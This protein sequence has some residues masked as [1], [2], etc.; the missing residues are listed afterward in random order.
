MWF[1]KQNGQ[2]IK[3]SRQFYTILSGTILTFFKKVYINLKCVSH[4]VWILTNSHWDKKTVFFVN[5]GWKL[6][7]HYY[8]FYSAGETHNITTQFWL[9]KI[10]CLYK[11]ETLANEL[12]KIRKDW[13]NHKHLTGKKGLELQTKQYPNF[14]ALA[15]HT[16]DSWWEK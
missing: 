3:L 2:V 13:Q 7:I 10:Q 4:F 15:C 11:L 9:Y 14:N 16:L 1:S 5:L 12:F 6:N 8:H